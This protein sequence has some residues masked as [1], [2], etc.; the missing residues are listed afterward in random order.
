MAL[1]AE[2]ECAIATHQRKGGD[3]LEQQK[4]WHFII[5][6]CISAAPSERPERLLIVNVRGGDTLIA[7]PFLRDTQDSSPNHQSLSRDRLNTV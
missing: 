2:R 3:P 7:F 5:I 4:E 6:R 1:P